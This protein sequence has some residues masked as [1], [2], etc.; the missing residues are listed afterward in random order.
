MSEDFR[1]SWR[2]ED[3]A[4]ESAEEEQLERCDRDEVEKR[5]AERHKNTPALN[6]F[7]QPPGGPKDPL[8]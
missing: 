3:K 7:E 5:R 1:D 6:P 8:S 4:M 2:P